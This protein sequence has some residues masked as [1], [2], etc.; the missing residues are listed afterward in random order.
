MLKPDDENTRLRLV[1]YSNLKCPKT[2]LSLNNM[3]MKGPNVLG[4]I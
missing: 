1:I 4:D 2:G 3:M